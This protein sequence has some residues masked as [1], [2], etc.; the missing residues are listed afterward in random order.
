MKFVRSLADLL[1]QGQQKLFFA[2]AIKAGVSVG[3]EK[4]RV[5]R[6]SNLLIS[7]AGD[8]FELRSRHNSFDLIA[9]RMSIPVANGQHC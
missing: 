9:L 8:C 1:Q 3:G 7:C 2:I 5:P 6:E 4:S